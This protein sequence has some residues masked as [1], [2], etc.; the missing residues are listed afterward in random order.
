MHREWY[1]VELGP[2][3]LLTVTRCVLQ[4]QGLDGHGQSQDRFWTGDQVEGH[5]ERPPLLKIGEP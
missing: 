2:S 4:E 5:R 3:F 1:L